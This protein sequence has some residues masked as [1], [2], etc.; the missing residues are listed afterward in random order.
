MSTIFEKK[1]SDVSPT[2][3]QYVTC[4][5]H[6]RREILGRFSNHS[7]RCKLCE[8]F[9]KRQSQRLLQPQ[10]KT[11]PISII[12]EKKISDIALTMM[13]DV[14]YFNYFKREN[15]RPFSNHDA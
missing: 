10:W 4:A 12:S 8:P 7:V 6:F 14:S 2:T 15:G 5:I 13:E 9:Q 11:E 1:F 3:M